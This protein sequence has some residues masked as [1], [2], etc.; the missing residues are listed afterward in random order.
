MGKNDEG[1]DMLT[2]R[3]AR[4]R[5]LFFHLEGSPGSHVV[6]RVDKG[7]PPDEAIL[8]AAELAVQFSK[9]KNA[10]RAPVHIAEIKDISKPKGAKPGLVYVHRGRTLQLRRD[11]ARLA[12][13][14]E[15]RIED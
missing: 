13:I 3:L 4:G 6:L 5:D 1:N 14:T 2:T 7:D 11:P 12:R 8:E 10:S 15:A 9:Q